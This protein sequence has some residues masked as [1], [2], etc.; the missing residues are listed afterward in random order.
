MGKNKHSKTEGMEENAALLKEDEV[1]SD[2][3]TLL[4]INET[5]YTIASL[6]SSRHQYTISDKDLTDFLNQLHNLDNNIQ[7]LLGNF[8]NYC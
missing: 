7:A 8:P 3:I 2:E 6:T 4:N 1:S 5:K